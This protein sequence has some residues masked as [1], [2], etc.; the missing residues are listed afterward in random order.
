MPEREACICSA[1]QE[2]SQYVFLVLPS[3]MAFGGSHELVVQNHV[4]VWERSSCIL[5]GVMSTT[6]PPCDVTEMNF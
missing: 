3:L 4:V 5:W 2:F 6:F 1:T